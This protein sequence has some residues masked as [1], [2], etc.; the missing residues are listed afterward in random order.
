MEKLLLLVLAVGIGLVLSLQP[1]INAGLARFTGVVESSAISFGVGAVLLFAAA[2]VMGKG[3]LLA[4]TQAPPVYWLG[5]LLGAAYVTFAVF[6][7]PRIGALALM[8]SVIVGQLTA[9]LLI[10][11]FGILG[12]PVHPVSWHRIIGLIVML[13]GLRLVLWK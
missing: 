12:V 3:S 8:A 5:G 9:S 1:P 2:L 4:A 13:G 7:V 10:D 6:L 11:H